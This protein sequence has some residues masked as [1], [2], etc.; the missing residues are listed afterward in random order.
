MRSTGT[1]RSIFTGTPLAKHL[2]PDEGAPR[3]RRGLGRAILLALGILVAIAV[4][5]LAGVSLVQHRSP[6]SVLA[7]TIV[8]PPEQLF[9]KD[10]LLVLVVGLDYDYN[11][12]DEAYSSQSRSDVIMAVNFDLADH[13]IYELSVPRDMDAI[14]PGGV[15]AKIN[16]AQADGGIAESEAVVAQWLGIPG[17][18]RYV[19]LRINTTKDLIDAIGGVD[20]N[21]E[22][23]DALTHRGKNGPIN[24]DDTWGHLHV[25]LQPGLQHLNGSQAVGYARFRHDWCSDPCRIM[26]QQQVIKAIADK[27]KSNKLNTLLHLNELLAV[28]NRDVQTD[29]TPTEELSLAT[30]FADI[31]PSE[32]HT[33]Q[34]PYVADKVLPNWGDVIIPD[35]TKKAEL[36]QNMLISP[37]QPQPTPYFGQVAAIAPS[38]LRVDVENGTEI[39]GLA[40]KVAARLKAQG[41]EV[42]SV[43]NASSSGVLT[44][45]LHEHSPIAFAAYRVRQALGAAAAKAKIVVDPATSASPEPH[46]SDVTV[47]VGADLAAALQKKATPT[48]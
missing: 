41:F 6:F 7:G 28:F 39:A 48:P 23:S 20:V 36:V 32:I 35:E 3:R 45:Q 40:T 8:P 25:H 9:G 13:R 17:F 38:T 44:T 31:S 5:V 46:A 14:L 33:A 21:V 15:E 12:L 34:V 16:Q 19:V 47:I 2:A 10:H 30:A 22:N 24:Y 27:L 1:V 18:D 26:R 11:N 29:F 43:G 4:A 37:P 42:G